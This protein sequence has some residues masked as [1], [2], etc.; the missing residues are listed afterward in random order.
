KTLRAIDGAPIKILKHLGRGGQGDVYL[1]EYKN[2][3]KA[4]KWYHTLGKHPQAFYDNMINMMK[5]GAPNHAFLWPEAITE[6]SDHSFGYIMKLRP[7]GYHELSEFMLAKVKFAS[8]KVAVDSCI[9]IVSAFRALHNKGYSY[10][11]LNDGNFFIN[12]KT[13][14]VMICDND[15]VAPDGYNMGI[16]GK[17]RYMAPEVVIGKT[18]PNTQTDCFSLSVVLF[19][20]LFMNHPLEGRRALVPCLTQD[21]A[22]MLYGSQALFIYDPANQKLPA[23][24]RNDPV[25]NIHSNVIARWGY[26]P[27][28][29]KNAFLHAFSQEVIKDPNRRM[30]ELDWLCVLTRF[31]SDIADCRCGSEVFIQNA[32]T[33]KCDVCGKPLQIYNTIKLRDYTM[34]AFAGAR[35][36]RCQLGSCNESQALDPMAMVLAKP[37][38]PSVLGLMNVSKDTWPAKT[39]TGA[40]RF[41]KPQE[42]V[43]FKAGIELDLGTGKIVLG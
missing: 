2:E 3:K 39:T 32:A 35:I 38:D 37:D 24:Q 7:D 22:E 15:N 30:T 20:I 34:P 1:V 18:K 5:K 8:F 43:P 29:L 41:V 33:T 12:P 13:G 42:I 21:L 26:M 19:L 16:I 17:P 4:L 27:E 23:A 28:Y 31:R 11:D 6:K 25:R 10:Q 40:V 9:Q 36:Y 14:D